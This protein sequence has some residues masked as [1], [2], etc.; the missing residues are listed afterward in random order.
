MTA[1]EQVALAT[2]AD[3]QA[4]LRLVGIEWEP[5]VG[6]HSRPGD[7]YVWVCG[8]AGEQSAVSSLHRGVLYV[9]VDQ[10]GRG[11]RTEY[12][13]RVRRGWH[14]HGLALERM[15]ATALTGS[16]SAAAPFSAHPGLGAGAKGPYVNEVPDGL[17]HLHADISAGRVVAAAERLA[18]RLCMHV[19]AIGAAVNSQYASAWKVSDSLKPYDDLAYWVADYLRE[20]RPTA[21]ASGER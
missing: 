2:A 13:E 5:R 15:H 19:G 12:E 6:E 21:P 3:L 1:I 17:R 14:G 18:V 4:G 16:V 9:G 11:G 7:M 20:G 8:D 10:S